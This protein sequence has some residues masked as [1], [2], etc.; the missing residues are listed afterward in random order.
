MVL[1]PLG[2]QGTPWQREFTSSRL[3]APGGLW[4]E[5]GGTAISDLRSV[6]CLLYLVI[7]QEGGI[8][9]A[10]IHKIEKKEMI[11]D[12]CDALDSYVGGEICGTF[13]NASCFSFF[14]AQSGSARPSGL[15]TN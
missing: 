6:R 3:N 5:N 4:Q 11:E 9:P 7:P 1:A 13:G 12:A 8:S 10:A 14:A 15:F 2:A